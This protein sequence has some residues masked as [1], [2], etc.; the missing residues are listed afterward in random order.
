VLFGLIMTLTF[1]LGSGLTAEDGPEGVRQLLIAA[2][3]CNV[4]WGIID[5]TLLFMGRVSERN[6]K[7]RLGEAVR[8]APSRDA[9]LA[10]VRGELEGALEEIASADA[11]A[12]LYG[13]VVDGVKADGERRGGTRAEDFQAA[14]L[15]F[16]LVFVWSLP[17]AAPFCLLDD[18]LVALR[19]S[20][21]I[22]IGL[23]FVTGWRW[24]RWTGG[25]RLATGASMA[26]LGA[27]LVV[28]AIALGG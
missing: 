3:G 22:L 9:A 1:T 20:N 23:I 18:K 17:A 16:A 25:N 11:R 7:A 4:A 2:V 5:G 6:R 27:A 10:L 26:G 8:A 24:A 12:R 21:A 14:L 19:A 28:V 13:A 15:A